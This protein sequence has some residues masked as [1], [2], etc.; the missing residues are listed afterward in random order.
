MSALLHSTFCTLFNIFPI[1]LVD[2]LL[3][4]P[5]PRKKRSVAYEGRQKKIDNLT[6]IIIRGKTFRWDRDARRPL[7]NVK[8]C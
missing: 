3:R 1:H 8:Q 2:N 6:S 4:L 7:L 5:P